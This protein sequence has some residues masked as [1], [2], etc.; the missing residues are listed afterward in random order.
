MPDELLYNE[1][2]RQSFEKQLDS[3]CQIE[4]GKLIRR[5]NL[6]LGTAYSFSATIKELQK[7]RFFCEWMA[8]FQCG[9]MKRLAVEAQPGAVILVQ[10]L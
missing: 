4:D 9:S 8:E 5:Y 7:E 3:S 1:E 6:A 10:A 2:F